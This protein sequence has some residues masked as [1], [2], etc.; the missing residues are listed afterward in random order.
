MEKLLIS[1]GE[2]FKEFQ[3]GI[4]RNG[5]EMENVGKGLDVFLWKQ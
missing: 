1:E 2:V 5:E 4:L 3:L